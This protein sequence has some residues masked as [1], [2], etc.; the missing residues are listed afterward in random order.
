LRLSNKTGLAAS[1]TIAASGGRARGIGYGRH[2][3]TLFLIVAEMIQRFV[4]SSMLA[5][6]QDVTEVHHN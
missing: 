3:Y 2:W 6:V 1:P 4:Q 5:A